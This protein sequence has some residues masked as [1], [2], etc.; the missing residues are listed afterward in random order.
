MLLLEKHCA[1]LAICAYVH[2]E[3]QILQFVSLCVLTHMNTSGLIIII[4][5]YCITPHTASN[6]L[7]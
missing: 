5:S 6:L 4:I 1:L 7:N 3:A 2:I